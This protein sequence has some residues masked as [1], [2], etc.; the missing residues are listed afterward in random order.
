MASWLW[1]SSAES[2]RYGSFTIPMAIW[3]CPGSEGTTMRSPA[4]ISL[5][6][7]HNW[8]ALESKALRPNPGGLINVLRQIVLGLKALQIAR[9]AVERDLL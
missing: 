3:S 5:A 1:D 6:N 7:L 2:C 8:S 9:A 4:R